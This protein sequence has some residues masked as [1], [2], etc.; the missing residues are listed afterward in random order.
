MISY[1]NRK[2]GFTLIELLVVIA[3]IGILSSVVLASLNGSRQKGRDAKRISDI[4][5]LQLALELYYDSNG[6]YPTSISAAN[7]VTPGYI[8]VIPTD[9]SS[10]LPY[11]YAALQGAPAIAANCVSY[12]LGAKLEVTANTALSQD[13]DATVGGGYTN[14]PNS[15][16]TPCTGGT[17][18]GNADIAASAGDF[19]GADPIYDMRP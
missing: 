7:I 11:A 13:L 6:A 4:K 17:W 14:N 12:H 8:S 1:M 9:P 5:Q 10:N 3:I 2:R 19:S 16:G 15:D 18:A